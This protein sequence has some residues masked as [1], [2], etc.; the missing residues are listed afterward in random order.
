MVACACKEG[1]AGSEQL[2]RT[3]KQRR[4]PR[5]VVTVRVVF[6]PGSSR[7]RPWVAF[8]LAIKRVAIVP[9]DRE[10]RRRDRDSNY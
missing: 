7:G 8:E 2:N 10:E 9:I 6:R 3:G 1:G 5:E 4:L